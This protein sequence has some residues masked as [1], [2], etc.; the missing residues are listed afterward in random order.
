MPRF[1]SLIIAASL[2]AAAGACAPVVATQG[3]QAVDVK[4]QDIEAGVDTRETVLTK[5]G[6]PSTASTF[7][8]E[9]VWYYLTQTTQRYT[10]NK[11]KV[12]QRTVT[13]ITFN[14][15]DGKVATVRNLGLEDGRQIA[16]E[17]R[18][19][20]TRGRQLTILEQLLG[21]VGRG[22]LPRTEDDVPGQRRPD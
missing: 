14:E 22:Q 17:S 1:T 2:A 19:T 21:N 7:E 13:E 10:Y 9:N 3:F 11:P 12:S 6:T 8:A 4:P 20:P 16:M 15:A 5:L 18:E